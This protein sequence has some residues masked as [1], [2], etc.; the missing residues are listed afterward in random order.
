MLTETG[1]KLLHIHF[2]LDLVCTQ[3]YHHSI[4]SAFK[5]YTYTFQVSL[6]LRSKESITFLTFCNVAFDWK[7]GLA[8]NC[9]QN[10][11]IKYGSYS[12]AQL[13]GNECMC[14]ILVRNL[15]ELCTHLVSD[16]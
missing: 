6:T 5:V 11:I 4:I 14:V 16:S 15:H 7:F 10:N 9:I 3:K 13:Q 1:Q 12:T 2:V 8:K